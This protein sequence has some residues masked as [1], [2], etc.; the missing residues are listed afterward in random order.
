MLIGAI[1]NH[2]LALPLRDY[3]N[4][5]D[6]W[7]FRNDMSESMQMCLWAKRLEN[8]FKDGLDGI[9]KESPKNK[10]KSRKPKEPLVAARNDYHNVYDIQ[11]NAFTVPVSGLLGNHEESSASQMWQS[12]Q[13]YLNGYNS[14]LQQV[15]NGNVQG[16]YYYGYSFAGL[17][18][19]VLIVM[20][21]FVISCCMI[22][23]LSGISCYLFGKSNR[24]MKNDGKD[25][26]NKV[27]FDQTEKV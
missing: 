4:E 14:A 21:L 16:S 22:I 1:N 26:V 2:G 13:A 27:G 3:K 17:L 8:G 9:P 20:I 11:E 25:A 19:M 10:G 7:I 6:E 24:M 18:P 23:G 12:Q 15:N 5:N